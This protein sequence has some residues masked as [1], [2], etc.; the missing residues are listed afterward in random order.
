MYANFRS[1]S[2]LAPAA[3]L[4]G[5][6]NCR[7]LAEKSLERRRAAAQAVQTLVKEE[8]SRARNSNP[9]PHKREG[10]AEE[11]FR[12]TST[13]GGDERVHSKI[14]Q[15]VSALIMTFLNSP[16]QH[17]RKGGL[18]GIAAVGLALEVGYP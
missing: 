9:A 15:I 12:E 10:C 11:D 14:S 4:L 13:S 16:L 2:E 3:S 18:L 17:M 1:P 8:I 5:V 6:E 7:G